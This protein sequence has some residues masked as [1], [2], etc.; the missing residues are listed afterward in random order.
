MNLNCLLENCVKDATTF[1]SGI[2]GDCLKHHLNCAVKEIK[3]AMRHYDG[4]FTFCP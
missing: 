3:A 4:L 1:D 2:E